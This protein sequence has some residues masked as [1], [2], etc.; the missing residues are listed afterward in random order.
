MRIKRIVITSNLPL[1]SFQKLLGAR[2]FDRLYERSLFTVIYVLPFIPF[3]CLSTTEIPS[4]TYI[5]PQ[6]HISFGKHFGDN[7]MIR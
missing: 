5:S 1:E 7:W 2:I 6:F 3:T 4:F